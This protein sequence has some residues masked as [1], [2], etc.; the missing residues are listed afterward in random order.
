MVKYVVSDKAQYAAAISS[1]N[2][3]S[4]FGGRFCV[5]STRKLR[6]LIPVAAKRIMRKARVKKIDSFAKL[7]I[8]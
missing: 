5:H 2:K 1:V 4:G 3:V 7:L 6:N 8:F